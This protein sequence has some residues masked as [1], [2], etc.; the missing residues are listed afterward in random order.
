VLAQYEKDKNAIIGK[1]AARLTTKLAMQIAAQAAATKLEEDDPLAGALL[2]AFV[3]VASGVWMAIEE[4]DLRSWRTLPR[5]I[6]Y[7]RINDLPP[8]EHVVRIDYGC[9]IQ[10]KRINLVKDKIGIAYFSYAR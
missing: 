8:G 6:R 5:Q 2:K 1:I 10:E 7:L 4:A 3:G 9:G